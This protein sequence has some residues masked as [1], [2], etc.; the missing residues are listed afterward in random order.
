[1]RRTSKRS[2]DSVAW[3]LTVEGE[4]GSAEREERAGEAVGQ[5]REQQKLLHIPHRVQVGEEGGR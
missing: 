5:V 4:V 3:M 2:D 1:M